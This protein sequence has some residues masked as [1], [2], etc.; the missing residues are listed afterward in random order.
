MKA[1]KSYINLTLF[2]LYL[3]MEQEDTLSDQAAQQFQKA[4][5]FNNGE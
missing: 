4:K 1:T 5:G 3:P 2:N